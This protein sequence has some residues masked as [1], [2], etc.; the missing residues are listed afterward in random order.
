MVKPT[1][2]ILFYESNWYGESY[3]NLWLI[4]VFLK[5]DKNIGGFPWRREM[6]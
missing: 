1:A 6:K 2:L 5:L 3:H 4:R